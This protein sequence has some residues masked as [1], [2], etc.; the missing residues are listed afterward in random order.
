MTF[1]CAN[2]L[3]IFEEP[4]SDDEARKE[5]FEV[6]GRE[7]SAKKDAKV[8]TECYKILMERMIEAKKKKEK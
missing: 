3:D 7:P 4:A 8:C 2:C 6:F 1:C 5:F